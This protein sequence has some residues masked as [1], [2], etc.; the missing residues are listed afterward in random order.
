MP[1]FFEISKASE[2][3]KGPIKAII[4]DSGSTRLLE[5]IQDESRNHFVQ[6]YVLKS[7]MLE[8]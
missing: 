7:K 4:L 6:Y 5:P 2:N 3:V 8:T 1:S